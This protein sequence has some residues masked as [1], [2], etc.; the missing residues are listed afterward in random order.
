MDDEKQELETMSN[1]NTTPAIALPL[2]A[3]MSVD[4][5]FQNVV[6][7]VRAFNGNAEVHER[8]AQSIGVIREQLL[9]FAQL[10]AAQTPAAVPAEAAPAAEASAE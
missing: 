9:A 8:L 3:Q 7:V 4:V 10:V 2:S 5:A 6:N 1:E